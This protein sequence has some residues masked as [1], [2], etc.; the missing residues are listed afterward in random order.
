MPRTPPRRNNDNPYLM[1]MSETSFQIP[2]CME[3]EPTR[4]NDMEFDF[5]AFDDDTALDGDPFMTPLPHAKKQPLLTLQELTPR[6]VP[7]ESRKMELEARSSSEMGKETVEIQRHTEMQTSV[8]PAPPERAIVDDFFE[9]RKRDNYLQKGLDLSSKST[10][11]YRHD[12]SLSLQQEDIQNIMQE[13]FPDIADMEEVEEEVAPVPEVQSSEP[14]V[15][16]SRPK[17]TVKPKSK[18]R[19][20]PTL[21]EAGIVKQKAR[22]VSTVSISRP[23]SILKNAKT[24][25][26]P[27]SKFKRSIET[28]SRGKDTELPKLDEIVQDARSSSKRRESG[29][30]ALAALGGGLFDVLLGYGEKLRGSFGFSNSGK[31]PRQ[32]VSSETQAE[33]SSPSL[34][35]SSS[36]EASAT[37]SLSVKSDALT[38]SQ[39]TPSRKRAREMLTESQ[40]SPAH[41]QPT[42][43]EAKDEQVHS[44]PMRVPVK[45]SSSA[46][47]PR[48]NKKGRT[49]ENADVG[50][51]ASISTSTT[52]SLQSRKPRSKTG[53]IIGKP[54]SK[55]K[56]LGY[57]QNINRAKSQTLPRGQGSSKVPT[58]RDSKHGSISSE[59]GK[60]IAASLSA[61]SAPAFVSDVYSRLTAEKQKGKKPESVEDKVR[62]P[63]T[64]R[65]FAR[66]S[67][68]ARPAVRPTIPAA[69]NF[70]STTRTSQPN[71]EFEEKKDWE[72]RASVHHPVPDFAA[73]HAAQAKASRKKDLPPVTLPSEAPVLNT[74]LRAAERAKFDAERKERERALEIQREVRERERAEQDDREYREARKR[75]VIRAHEVP[76]WYKDVP[77][78]K[79]VD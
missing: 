26:L 33:A 72:A 21:K 24:N 73:L 25:P 50:H 31:S 49:D 8:R 53:P 60:Q 46:T 58:A 30:S 27:Q 56:P 2:Q 20:T 16:E 40:L 3:D 77:K 37:A 45:R 18:G 15:S 35:K 48:Q 57:S 38:L 22:P 7:E 67:P 47:F 17:E 62:K 65:H 14:A 55:P 6:I 70:Q 71:T 68:P 74:T 76:E 1:D 52:E 78:R 28:S 51:L 39:L 29:G 11:R 23:K 61:K 75:T 42:L 12:Q 44:S 34:S 10:A 32:E 64:I 59:K 5:D 54:I 13:S 36:P 66:P 19:R 4:L 63:G 41:V 43:I 9:R 69:F 79:E